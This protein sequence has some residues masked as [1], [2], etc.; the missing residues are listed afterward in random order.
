MARRTGPKVRVS[1]R[2]GVALT[3]KA[4]RILERRPNI[5]G[6]HGTSRRRAKESDYGRQLK[7]KQKLREY[8]GV[9]ERQFRRYVAAARAAPGVTGDTLVISLE[10]R[11]DNLV[12]RLGFQRSVD[13]ARQLVNHGHILVNGKRVDIPSY[14][15][16]VGD[17]I[18]VKPGSRN[19][20][21][22]R[23]A[24][25]MPRAGTLSYLELNKA[26][27]S[28]K[29]IATPDPKEVPIQVDVQQ[30]VEYYSKLI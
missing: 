13:G 22:I 16:S 7:E 23:E 17:E 1:R 14:R 26:E 19:N 8:Y 15:V 2:L 28:G 6:Q 20:P 24:I 5:P 11:L 21:I 3:D 10:S 25:T 30:V 4:A 27:L 12:Y 9:M 29:L 18:A